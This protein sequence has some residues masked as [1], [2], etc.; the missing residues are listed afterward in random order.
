MQY[1]VLYYLDLWDGEKEGF[2]N[3]EHFC[4]W[5]GCT[6]YIAIKDILLKKID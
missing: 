5:Y 4:N 6:E 3:F 1:E 2:D